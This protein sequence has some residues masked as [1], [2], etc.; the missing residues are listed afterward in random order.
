MKV[1]NC[2]NCGEEFTSFD[3]RKKHCSI[4]CRRRYSVKLRKSG[5]KPEQPKKYV[6][7]SGIFDWDEY[8]NEIIV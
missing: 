2:M 8:D 3:P 1:K 6:S 4:E 7:S 5:K